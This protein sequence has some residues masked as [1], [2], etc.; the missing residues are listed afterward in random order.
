[1]NKHVKVAKIQNPR[2][3]STHC[4]AHRATLRLSVQGG[5][6]GP[7]MMGGL[8]PQRCP[9]ERSEKGRAYFSDCRNKEAVEKQSLVR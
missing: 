3:L 1:V 7:V 4:T 6:D 2:Q 5:M 8:A 9:A